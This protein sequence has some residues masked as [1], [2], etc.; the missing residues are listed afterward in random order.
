MSDD[1]KEKKNKHQYVILLENIHFG[2]FNLVM[3]LG[4]RELVKVGAK[5][6]VIGETIKTRVK[7][8][9]T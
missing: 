5:A 2:S 8:Q 3:K 7:I 1:E 9:M 4:F 6:V